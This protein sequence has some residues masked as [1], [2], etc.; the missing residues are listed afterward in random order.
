MS[1][2]RVY[3]NGYQIDDGH[4]GFAKG[5]LWRV[6]G[7]PEDS[8]TT[9]YPTWGEAMEWATMPPEKKIAQLDREATE[10]GGW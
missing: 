4:K 3:K 2:I 9:C 5:R 10:E 6:S 1:K 8:R 7:V